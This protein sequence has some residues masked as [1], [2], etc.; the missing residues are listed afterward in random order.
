[1]LNDPSTSPQTAFFQTTLIIM[2]EKSGKESH[3]RGNMKEDFREAF[4]KYL[5]S[6]WEA[7]GK[8][9]GRIWAPSEMHLE[10]YGRH[11]G[12]PTELAGAAKGR[13]CMKIKYVI[14]VISRLF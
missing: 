7:F 9:L 13:K 5:E 11:W 4:G 8:H 10:T 14:E 12:T 6:I 3:G 1:M 2:E